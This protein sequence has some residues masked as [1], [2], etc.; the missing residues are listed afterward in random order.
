MAPMIPSCQMRRMAWVGLALIF[1]GTSIVFGWSSWHPSLRHPDF[2]NPNGYDDLVRAGTLLVGPLPADGNLRSAD[3]QSLLKYIEANREAIDLVRLG[4]GRTCRVPL[5]D[6]ITEMPRLI[7]R[8]NA[9][10]GLVKGLEAAGLLAHREGR[11][12]E[13]VDAYLDAIRLGFQS[14]HGGLIMNV[15]AGH[16]C[17]EIGVRGLVALRSDLSGEI[18]REVVRVLESLRDG[19]EPIDMVVAREQGWFM[20]ADRSTA[21]VSLALS[22]LPLSTLQQSAIDS[23]RASDQWSVARLNLLLADLAIRLHRERIGD[24]PPTLADLVPRDLASVPDDPFGDSRPLVY[25]TT[26]DGFL[27]YSLGPDRDD[28][29]GRPTPSITSGVVEDGDLRLDPAPT[30]ED[31]P[32]LGS[33]GWSA[34]ASTMARIRPSQ[35]WTRASA[36]TGQPRRPAAADVRGLMLAR[37]TER[38]TSRR[39]DSGRR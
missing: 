30:S 28:D 7:D 20:G 37:R 34:S 12:G 2:P 15:Q 1:T 33:Q 29:G 6:S 21:E 27:L 17:E 22:V 38:P 13:A 10:R 25:R 24:Y 18:G 5:P 36:A 4:L 26:E 39:A 16:A 31:G 8:I 19:R 32:S 9:M 11:R 23:A 14:A 3:D 35:S